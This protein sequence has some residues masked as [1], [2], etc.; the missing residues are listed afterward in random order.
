[1]AF[2]P[3]RVHTERH[4]TFGR[5]VHIC[6]GQHLARA[7]LEEGVHVIA[8]RIAKPRLVGE[9]KWRPYLGIWGIHSLPIAFEPA[10]ARDSSPRAAE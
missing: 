6:I 3:E 10:P 8:Q 2:N 5:G 1:M 9:V 7:Q 4:I